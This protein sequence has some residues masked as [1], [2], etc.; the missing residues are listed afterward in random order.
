[1][2]WEAGAPTGSLGR[3]T[4]TAVKAFQKD[5]NLVDDGICG[6]LTW[7]AVQ[8]HVDTSDPDTA[9]DDETDVAILWTVTARDLS[10][11]QKDDAL[12]AYPG[13]TAQQQI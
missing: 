7:K 11:Q 1:M 4:E 8:A 3:Q 5:N 10:T 6:K 13:A 9:E 12:A 2:T